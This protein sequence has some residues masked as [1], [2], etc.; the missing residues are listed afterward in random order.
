MEQSGHL[1]FLH[2]R[3]NRYITTAAVNNSQA[4]QHNNRSGARL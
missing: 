4:S 2:N 3:L 1:F